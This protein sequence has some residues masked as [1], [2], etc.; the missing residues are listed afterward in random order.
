[1]AAHGWYNAHWGERGAD[2]ITLLCGRMEEVVSVAV[3]CNTYFLWV[4]LRFV[5]I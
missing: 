2:I 3:I 4:I 5:N 1:M